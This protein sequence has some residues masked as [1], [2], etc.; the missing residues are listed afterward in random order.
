MTFE[1]CT[2]MFNA[3]FLLSNS[4]CSVSYK[5]LYGR[6]LLSHITREAYT[7]GLP[8]CMLLSSTSE[9]KRTE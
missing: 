8:L 7:A 2:F 1:C 9:W 4:V 5:I 6:A 3:C